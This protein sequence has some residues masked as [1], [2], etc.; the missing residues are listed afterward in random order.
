[1]IN[2][3]NKYQNNIP[4]KENSQIKDKDFILKNI[5]VKN[6]SFSYP[7]NKNLILNNINLKFEQN[8][9]YCLIGETG[10]GKSTLMDIIL[11]LLNPIKGKIFINNN[12]EFNQKDDWWFDKISYVP[13]EP[14]L[15]N[16]VNKNLL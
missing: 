4:L 9:I 8:K 10:C 12:T 11:G 5:L 3:F 15:I 2:N 1:M 13:Q 16:E 14:F 7:D 6:L